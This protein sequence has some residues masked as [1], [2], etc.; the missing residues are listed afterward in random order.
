MNF[1]IHMFFNDKLLLH[2]L[3]KSNLVMIFFFLKYIA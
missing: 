2:S 1:I 3:D